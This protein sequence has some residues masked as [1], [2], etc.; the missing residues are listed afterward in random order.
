M[1]QYCGTKNYIFEHYGNF[2]IRPNEISAIIL[3]GH[4]HIQNGY[5]P[6]K[7]RTI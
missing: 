5:Q 2:E 1:K 3:N 4:D 6:T 7:R